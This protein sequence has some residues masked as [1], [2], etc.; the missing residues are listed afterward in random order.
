MKSEPISTK[1]L[2]CLFQDE[3]AH[4]DGFDEAKHR[5]PFDFVLLMCCQ[6]VA[7][8]KPFIDRKMAVITSGNCAM[9]DHVGGNFS[10][11]FFLKH[12]G[13]DKRPTTLFEAFKC[14]YAKVKGEDGSNA[15]LNLREVTEPNTFMFI[16]PKSSNLDCAG[17][18]NR[19]FC[20][21]NATPSLR[22]KTV[23]YKP[24]TALSLPFKPV[25]STEA[26][27]GRDRE[28]KLVCEMLTDNPHEQK[29]VV[30]RG[31]QHGGKSIIV[32]AVSGR[33]G[34]RNHYWPVVQ[35]NNDLPSS[36]TGLLST[37][38]DIAAALD[39]HL[40]YALCAAL[41]VDPKNAADVDLSAV[42]NSPEALIDFIDK[43]GCSTPRHLI[44]DAFEKNQWL[45]VV[46]RCDGLLTALR[47]ELLKKTHPS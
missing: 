14:A 40:K 1:K 19:S 28:L 21:F 23:K 26:L 2:E 12:F 35:L 39:A 25:T 13:W 29:L 45:L 11:E 7:H 24:S 4:V 27:L 34:M 41:N 43:G 8:A 46:P 44:C 47:D 22:L 9:S 38:D 3:Y 16:E 32:E 31:L 36:V 33:L 17:Q 20:T 18:S 6:G 42:L 30:V 10:R 5:P 15:D 37:P